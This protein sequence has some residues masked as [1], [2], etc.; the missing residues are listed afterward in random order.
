LG[1]GIDTARYAHHVSFLDEQKRTAAGAFHFTENADGYQKFEAAV[2]KLAA[3]YPD[4]HVHIRVDAAGQYAE[5]LL[6]W[7][8]R[9]PFPTTISV[10]QPARNKA[11]RTVHFD[12]RKADPTESLACA[13][14]AIVER[15]AA[16]PHNPPEFQQL[17]D[18]V[19][20]LEASAKQRT[21]LVNQLHGLLARIFP[22]L[23]VHAK[24]LSAGWVLTLLEAYPT[25]E[26]LAR[27]RRDTLAKIPHLKAELA[28]TL[29]AAAAQSTA[30]NRGG[31]AEQLI[32]QK[33][34]ALRHEQATFAAL[35]K[36]VEQAWNA[37]PDGP[38]RRLRTIPG[39]GPQ[40]AAALVAK[41]V[42]IDRFATPAAL[43]GYFGIFP[44]E[45][46]VSGT[47]R[48]GNPKHGTEIHMSRKGNDLVRRLLYTAAQCA[49]TWNPAVQ[50]LFARRKADGK[51][52][53]VCLGHGMAKLLRQV[54]AL[55]T[56]DCDFAPDFETKQHAARELVASEPVA[57]ESVASESVASES[58]ASESVASESVASESVASEPSADETKKVVGHKKAVQPQGKVVT[59]TASKITAAAP[60]NNTRRPLNFALLRQRFSITQVLEHLGWH[61][62]TANGTQSRGP[63]PVHEPAGAASRCFAVQT[64]KNVYCCHRCGSEG[65]A[66]D[67]WAAIHEQPI[68]V[69]AWDLV[70]TFGLEPPLLEAEGPPGTNH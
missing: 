17:R 48:H 27:A 59:T 1:V 57:S 51:H 10:G 43:I 46:D 45:V 21:R 62:Q 68:L 65:N 42:S 14:F 7:L 16:T 11:Y 47:D 70:T 39:I 30:S 3:K 38:H 52:Y 8:H 36:L 26:K 5:N 67:L 24:D 2:A 54:F 20:L 50:A 23:A 69:A 9:L 44:E 37:L 28:A 18:A 6:Q 40:T 64:E 19:A 58:V 29:H 15:P 56:K 22:E 4:V 32:L 35:A 31:V 66:L 53:N 63:C 12:K 13:R 60:A 33:V 61:P 55:W 34:G 49:V 41:I 25:P